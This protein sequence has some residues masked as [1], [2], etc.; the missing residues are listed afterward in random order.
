[1]PAIG[2]RAGEISGAD[3][4]PDERTGLEQV[5]TP[6][7]VIGDAETGAA[8]GQREAGDG[9]RREAIVGTNS[10]AID[11]RRRRI[12]AGHAIAVRRLRAA[13]ASRPHAPA[14]LERHR[15]WC[16]AINR[17]L[18]VVRIALLRGIG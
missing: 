3:T 15:N 13:E 17:R 1:L 6:G 16:L 14:L 8:A 12:G 18:R 5:G 4:V 7:A 9:E 10:R 2:E 11:L